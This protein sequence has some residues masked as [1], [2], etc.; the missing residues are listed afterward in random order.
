MDNVTIFKEEK[1]PF[2]M[3]FC[4]DGS[5][6]YMAGGEWPPKRRRRHGLLE[7]DNSKGYKGISL[8][9]YVADL[10]DFDPVGKIKFSKLHEFEA[11]KTS[12]V[13]MKELE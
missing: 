4:V 12:V 2:G 11:P 10:S 13:M 8:S 1:L 9:M 3:G 5:K 6:L 7:L